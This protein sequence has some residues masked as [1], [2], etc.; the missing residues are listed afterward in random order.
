MIKNIRFFLLWMAF[1]TLVS[2]AVRADLTAEASGK[3]QAR[4]AEYRQTVRDLHTNQEIQILTPE[5][6]MV[7]QAEFF[8]K[9][10]QFRVNIESQIPGVAELGLENM[11]AVLVSDGNSAW[12]VSPFTGKIELPFEESFKF[13]AQNSFWNVADSEGFRMKA[14]ADIRGRPCYVIE[15]GDENTGPV[16]FWADQ[17]TL[18]ILQS[19]Y[20]SEEGVFQVT[21]SDHR[22]IQGNLS[23]PYRI[24]IY[25][26]GRL[27]SVAVIQSV[28]INSG[29]QDAYFD[30]S[31]I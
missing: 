17:A 18:D 13:Y 26:D 21:Y 29:L 30:P 20:R 28:Q 23:L 14:T 24:E 2:A 11:N 27:L 25:Q 3:I 1:L 4:I 31:Q 12:M 15:I 10:R 6:S 8:Q 5:G 22:R 7:Q 19:E 16:I 9:G